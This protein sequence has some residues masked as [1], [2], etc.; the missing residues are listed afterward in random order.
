MGWDAALFIITIYF[1]FAPLKPSGRAFADPGYLKGATERRGAGK[2]CRE[3]KG[4]GAGWL[5][6]LFLKGR[7]EALKVRANKIPGDDKGG[8]NVR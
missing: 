7:E 3:E 4:R 5:A 1:S 8:G 2:H 6:L